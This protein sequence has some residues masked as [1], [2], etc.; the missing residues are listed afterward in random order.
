MEGMFY[1]AT[2]FNQNIK[3]WDVSNVTSMERMFYDAKSFNQ[4][5][6]NWCLSKNCTTNNMFEGAINFK[7]SKPSNK[8]YSLYLN[9][10]A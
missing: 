3:N 4:N 6:S 5:I 1:H 10:R 2:S 9:K 8:L 7:F